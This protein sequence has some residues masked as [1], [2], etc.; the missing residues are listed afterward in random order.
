MPDINPIIDQETKHAYLNGALS[1]GLAHGLTADQILPFAN[2]GY[3]KAAAARDLNS[4]RA[5]KLVNLCHT[6]G[7]RSTAAA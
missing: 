2:K 3:E 1:V 6:L 5:E 4:A 7:G